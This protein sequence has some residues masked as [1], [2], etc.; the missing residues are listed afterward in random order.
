VH[1]ECIDVMNFST[2]SLVT[3]IMWSLAN[4]M[5]IRQSATSGGSYGLRILAVCL[6]LGWG[7]GGG[8]GMSGQSKWINIQVILTF[9]TMISSCLV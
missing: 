5:M 6:G 4:C 9:Y 1:K 8:G 2:S 7:G 3:H